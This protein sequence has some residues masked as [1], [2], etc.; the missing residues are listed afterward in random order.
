VPNTHLVF[1]TPTPLI[2]SRTQLEQHGLGSYS[3][4]G[5]HLRRCP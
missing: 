3:F 5:C 1:K 4:E 2:F